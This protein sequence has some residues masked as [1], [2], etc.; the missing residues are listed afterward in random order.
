MIR[1]I[2]RPCVGEDT[3]TTTTSRSRSDETYAVPLPFITTAN[4]KVPPTPPSL[5][6]VAGEERPQVVLVADDPRRRIDDAD[7]VV[8][9]V[10]DD[11]RR[12]V[13]GDI[14][15]AGVGLHADADA[16][17]AGVAGGAGRE[18]AQSNGRCCRESGR[19]LRVDVHRIVVAACGVERVAIGRE[20]ESDV[21]VD[22]LDH[23]LQ[24]RLALGAHVVEED[25]L[26]RVRGIDRAVRPVERVLAG[27][28][29]RQRRAVRAELRAHRHTRD[30]VR[31]VRQ[32]RI[33]VLLHRIVDR[34]RRDVLTGGQLDDSVGSPMVVVAASTI[35]VVSTIVAVPPRSWWVR[36]PSKRSCNVPGTDSASTTPRLSCSGQQTEQQSLGH[37]WDPFQV[38]W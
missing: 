31:I 4:G 21:G 26:R 24:R 36:L 32:P 27:R 12:A 6:F 18:V 2:R 11:Q 23:L 19:R 15:A 38:G 9:V 37:T 33:Q 25:V 35:V 16:P 17:V 30:E 14:H 34:R 28:D 7:R 22:L 1:V 29:D 10:G 3:S 5:S 13:G 8:V 20:D